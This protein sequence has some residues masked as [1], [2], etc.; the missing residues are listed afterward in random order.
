M[1]TFPRA[2]AAFAAVLLVAC[3]APE[4]PLPGY[5]PDET[6]DAVG[7]DEAMLREVPGHPGRQAPVDLMILLMADG[8]SAE[9]AE[10]IALALDGQVVGHLGPIGAFQLRLPTTTMDELAAAIATASADP[11][12]EGAG[13]DF[14]VEWRNCPE[15]SDVDVFERPVSCPWETAEYHQALTA[16]S[17]LDV[18]LTDVS[19]GLIDSGL[20]WENGEFDRVTVA[21]AHA[22]GG[23]PA[24]LADGRG[25]GTRVAGIIAAD[26]EDWGVNGIASRF[27]GD[28]L[29]LIWGLQGNRS[30]ASATASVAAGSALAATRAG[31]SVVNMSFGLGPFA[32]SA[33]VDALAARTLLERIFELNPNVLFVA[34]AANEAMVLD[35]TNDAPAGIQAPNV[36]TVGSSMPCMP[37]ERAPLSAQGP[38]VE[39]VAQGEA[40]T[41]VGHTEGSATEVQSGTSF[42]APQVSSVAAILRSIAP[43]LTAAE[44]RDYI[45]G[46]ALPGPST[47]GGRALSV[48][49]PIL[50]LLLDRGTPFAEEVD[51]D[52]DGLAD[53]PGIVVGR[54]CGGSTYSVE[55]FGDFVY[56]TASLDLEANGYLVTGHALE[57]GFGMTLIRRG[58]DSF[59]AVCEDCAFDLGSFPLS[60]EGPGRVTWSM[61]PD[62]DP[63]AG[64]T[65]LTGTWSIDECTIVDRFASFLA[66]YDGPQNVLVRSTLAG[67]LEVNDGTMDE[68]IVV[69]FQGT[70]ELPFIA[71]PLGEDHPLTR[72]LERRCEGGR[73]R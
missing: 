45:L 50:Q 28:H 21:S 5:V 4:P 31:A 51:G 26:D 54:L 73:D 29:R 36:I 40:I 46:N 72:T 6:V 48:A 60:E 58:S 15:V 49:Q 3:S 7:A 17:E 12:V 14:V 52:A 59:T 2:T 62:T 24:G 20:Q 41:V 69:P 39:I 47:T 1:S 11:A 37:T 63:D 70:F 56:E 19:V 65:V 66:A 55:G 25:H 27:V 67:T 43:E 10:R 13:Y 32:S 64:G 33:D 71:E 38:R 8:S 61:G 68:G 16:F 18:D 35:G 30:S 42:A 34:A 53:R 22:V 9:D 44:T 23:D 57:S